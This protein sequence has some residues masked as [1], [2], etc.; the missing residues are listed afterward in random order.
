MNRKTAITAVLCASLLA[1]GWQRAKAT[2]L[3]PTC[4]T[5]T[6]ILIGGTGI[7]IVYKT[8]QC[9]A[10]KPRC[11]KCGAKLKANKCPTPDCQHFDTTPPTNS[12]PRRV[13]SLSVEQSSDNGQNWATMATVSAEPWLDLDNADI[14]IVSASSISDWLSQQV[15]PCQIVATNAATN[16]ALLRLTETV[17]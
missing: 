7:Y 2:I 11:P 6:V 17:E 4:L 10:K 15:N 13:S 9:E 3:I 5:V 1:C 12:P 8:K 16:A 14:E